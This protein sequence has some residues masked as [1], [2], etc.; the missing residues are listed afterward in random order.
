MAQMICFLD[1]AK[2]MKID[3]SM[4][5]FKVKK[6]FALNLLSLG[7][8]LWFP[9][10]FRKQEVP[11]VCSN[12]G[13]SCWSEKVTRNKPL[14]FE[15]SCS[16]PR[17]I[18]QPSEVLYQVFLIYFSFFVCFFSVCFVCLLVL[19]SSFSFRSERSSTNPT[20]FLNFT[21]SSEHQSPEYQ[22]SLDLKE[23]KT[24]PAC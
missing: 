20:D 8:F 11:I 15:T 3:W 14:L 10:T 4:V 6:L 5:D 17:P 19:I 1:Q 21:Y 16:S 22:W 7:V 9:L 18:W 12:C 24:T 23:T 2:E 13:W